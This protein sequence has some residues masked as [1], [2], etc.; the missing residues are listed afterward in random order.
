MLDY[1]LIQFNAE[2]LMNEEQKREKFIALIAKPKRVDPL[3][4][5]TV[6]LYW[7]LF[8]TY[9][10]N[11][12]VA[13]TQFMKESNL[14]ENTGTVSLNNEITS[15]EAYTL[16]NKNYQITVLGEEGKQ[17]HEIDAPE[18]FKLTNF[19]LE[20]STSLSP[21]YTDDYDVCLDICDDL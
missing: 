16:N 12:A 11:D 10:S 18:F 2:F 6:T 19:R 3:K 15:P 21:S 5:A 17:A 13:F 1:F 20:N 8:K 4:F 9:E 14:L 7:H